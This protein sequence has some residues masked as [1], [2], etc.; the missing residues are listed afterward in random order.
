MAK[1]LIIEDSSYQRRKIARVL[2]AEG[3]EV[4]QATNGREGVEMVASTGPD[5][6]LLDL[7]MPEMD[8]IEVLQEL[9]GQGSEI[10]TIVHTADIQ[11]TTRAACLELGAVAFVNKPAR[12]D[13]LREVVQRVLGSLAG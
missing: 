10:P 2:Q 5:L 1:I 12:A 8:G 4:V 9:S 3:H 6:I 7:I 11:E 13:D